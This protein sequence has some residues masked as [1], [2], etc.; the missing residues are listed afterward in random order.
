MA[1]FDIFETTSGG[2]I[3]RCSVKGQF[4]KARKLQELAE[5]SANQ[6]HAIDLAA[7]ETLPPFGAAPHK[8]QANEA[9]VARPAQ[10]DRQ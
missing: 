6:F 3:W 9:G 10:S 4:E 5:T 1:T 2:Y 8:F 7:G